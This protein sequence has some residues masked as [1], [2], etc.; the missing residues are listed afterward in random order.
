MPEEVTVDGRGEGL[1][2]VKQWK[3]VHL[4]RIPQRGREFAQGSRLAADLRDG[5]RW[6]GRTQSGFR[7]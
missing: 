1:I 6:G 7:Y 4:R 5:R 3:E 2:G